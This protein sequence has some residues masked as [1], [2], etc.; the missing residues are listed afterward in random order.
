MNKGLNHR[1]L[2]RTIQRM[3]SKQY[4]NYKIMN[5]KKNILNNVQQTS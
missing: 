5:L 1:V 3:I 4:V 2:H